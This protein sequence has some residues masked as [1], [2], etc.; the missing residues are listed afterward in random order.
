[1]PK[2]R[3]AVTF[4]EIRMFVDHPIETQHCS[5]KDREPLMKKVR[6]VISKNFELISEKRSEEKP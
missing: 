1:M 5:S 2:D 3:F 4:G 6:E